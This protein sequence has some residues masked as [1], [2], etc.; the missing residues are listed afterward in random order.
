MMSGSDVPTTVEAS[1]DTNMPSDEAREGGEHLAVR[2]AVVGELGTAAAGLPSVTSARV[3]L[4][5]W[6]CD[7]RKLID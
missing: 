1:I 5:R 6:P 7:S 3:R 4:E 2:H